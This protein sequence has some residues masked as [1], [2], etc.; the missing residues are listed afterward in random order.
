MEEKLFYSVPRQLLLISLKILRKEEDI[1]INCLKNILMHRLFENF[2]DEFEKHNHNFNKII[3]IL[4]C[5][6]R[7]PINVSDPKN[8]FSKIVPILCHPV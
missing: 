5:Q 6:Y 1:L 8:G 4:S 3:F 7:L 2:Y